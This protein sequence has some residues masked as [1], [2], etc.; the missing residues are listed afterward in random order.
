VICSE[1]RFFEKP[2]NL[3]G[4][5]KTLFSKPNLSRAGVAMNIIQPYYLII[6]FSAGIR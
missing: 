5:G 3:S 4:A 2:G 1:D 6:L